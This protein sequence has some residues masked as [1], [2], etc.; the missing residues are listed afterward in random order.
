MSV[1]CPGATKTEFAKVADMA[2]SVV[3]KL[4]VMEKFPVVAYALPR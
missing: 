3:F 1:L 4:R 2:N